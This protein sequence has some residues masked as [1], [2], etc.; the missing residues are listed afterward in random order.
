[1]SMYKNLCRLLFQL[2]PETAHHQ[3]ENFL[4]LVSASSFLQEVMAKVCCYESEALKQQ[5]CGLDFYHPIGLAAGFDKNATMIPA[6]SAL[7]F[8]F[9][10]IGTVTKNPQKGNPKPRLFRYAVEE[11][12]QNAM[13][14]NNDGAM[15]VATRLAKLY[16]YALPIGINLGKNKSVPQADAL[17]DYQGVLKDFLDVGDYYVFNLS[18]PNTPNLRELQNS[19]FVGE[20]FSMAKEHTHKPMFIKISPDMA[21][22]EALQV[23]ESA[24]SC[25]ASGIIATNTTID[26]SLLSGAKDFGGI[27]GAVLKTKSA[28][29]FKE[30]AKAFFG[31]AVLIAA[32]GIDDAQEAYKRIKMGASL[33]QIYTGLVFGGPTLCKH[34]NQ[35]MV[36]LLQEDGFLNI[37]DAIGA[38]L[39]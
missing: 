16:P 11:S 24:I 34:I 39:T 14:F 22:D 38:D 20:L 28:G 10:E 35:E 32:G 18:S 2:E 15:K 4:K 26:Y 17:K 13:G 6:L 33:V 8:S 7:G 27:S 21:M 19:T 29:V 36:A 30:I 3:A 31:K 9:V 25:G 5:V 1:M 37:K 23:C 12:L